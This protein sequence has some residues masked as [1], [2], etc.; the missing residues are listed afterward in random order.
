VHGYR[1]YFRPAPHEENVLWN[2]MVVP[3]LPMTIYG[4]IWYQGNVQTVKSTAIILIKHM[5]M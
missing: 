2:A 1:L 5:Y 4:A 3:L